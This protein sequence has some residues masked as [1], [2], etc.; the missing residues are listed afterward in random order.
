MSEWPPVHY[1]TLAWASKTPR[2]LL[3]RRQWEASR[4]EYQAAVPPLLAEV[5]VEISPAV[6]A[7]A[8]DASALLTRFDA[9]VGFSLLPFASI[10]LRSESASSSQI[11]NLTSG[12]RA[13]AETEIGERDSGNASL[14]VRNVR[15]LQAALALADRLDS[16]SV[17]DLHAALL[18]DHRPELTGRYRDE[19]VWIGGSGV[20]PHGAAFVPPRHERVESAIEDLIAFV[21]RT[22]VPAL[23]HAALAHAQ[24]ETI[25]PFPDGN[26]RTGRALVQAML[27]AARL[28]TTLTIPISAGLLHDVDAYYAALGAY[29]EGDAD[30]MVL[31][32][33]AASV[34]AV[35][36]GRVLVAD[37]EEVRA[38][39][40]DRIGGLRPHHSARRVAD[41]ALEQ[42]V[43]S[44]TLV[45]ER[46]G[47][48]AAG[49]YRALDALTE[50]GV[51]RTAN[52][53]RRNR[54]WIADDVIRA[55]DA[56]A[57]RAA[58]R[59]RRG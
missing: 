52:S 56:F 30:A 59:S 29:R 38:G 50:V 40:I 2:E 47:I 36:N 51:L 48:S 27:R 14:I 32:F 31:A 53:Y 39:W 16:R 21:A 46:L 1:E 24:F 6:V 42:P 34:F 45:A 25:H 23:T 33:S 44:S 58:R 5:P 3:T 41:L 11:E 13:I 22:D 37:L 57:D 19:Q 26:G 55:L 12:A 17:I 35:G 54:L 10:L 9:E 18:A 43:L 7:E 49:T 28:T 15:A 8:A 20:S 4:G